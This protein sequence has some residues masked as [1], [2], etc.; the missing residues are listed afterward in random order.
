M[1]SAAARARLRNDRQLISRWL[2]EDLRFGTEVPARLA[3]AM[4]Y[5]VLGRAKRIRAVLALESYLAAGGRQLQAV[6]PLC[7]GIEL[8]QAFSLVHDDLP[9]M[10]DDDFRRGKPSLHRR[11]DEA[12]AILAGDALLAFAFE[13]MLRC[14]VTP[15]RRGEVLGLMT[16][17]LGPAG[18]AGGQMLDLESQ[19]SARGARHPER[20]DK[21]KTAVFMAAAV[22]AGGVLA[23]VSAP[24]RK[25]LREAGLSLGML[26]QATDD[27]LD[28]PVAHRV[29][30]R[31]SILNPVLSP[32]RRGGARSVAGRERAC[33]DERQSLFCES[34]RT[35]RLFSALGGSYQFLASLP[36]V[37]MNRKR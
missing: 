37:V 6:R 14:P 3:T 28:G 23:G 5:A 35:E 21:L 27:R 31:G 24:R 10:D 26:F 15:I 16:A 34:R 2:V 13:L 7:S 8:V 36:E 11:F 1:T 33:V 30:G 19:R 17:A 25:Q 22:E 4:R 18:M 9:C 32:R 29:Q 20:V 12:T